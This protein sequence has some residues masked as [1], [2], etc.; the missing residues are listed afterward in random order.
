MENMQT[1]T[2]L[3]WLLKLTWQFIMLC[4][5]E[6]LQLHF[7]L[8][9]ADHLRRH[10]FLPAVFVQE[11]KHRVIKRFVR[12]RHGDRS[13]DEGVVTEVTDQH[14]H[15]ISM[16]LEGSVFHDERPAPSKLRDEIIAEGSPSRQILS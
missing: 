2:S 6:E 14:L 9:L 4:T 8:H 12:D 3:R 15:D 7:I 13:F 11:R 10:V 1:R 16:P 5:K